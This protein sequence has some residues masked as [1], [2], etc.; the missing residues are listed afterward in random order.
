VHLVGFYYK[1]NVY[2]LL[3]MLTTLMMLPVSLSALWCAETL[4][5]SVTCDILYFM[6]GLRE[7]S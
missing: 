7:N 4:V 2:K 5:L 3:L 6:L 1:E